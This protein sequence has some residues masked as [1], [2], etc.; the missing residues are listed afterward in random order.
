MSAFPMDDPRPESAPPPAKG[1]FHLALASIYFFGLAV[2][3]G[4]IF[5]MIDV[6]RGGED[7]VQRRWTRALV[8]LV[9]ADALV[10][11]GFFWV[12]NRSDEVFGAAFERGVELEF[13]IGLDAAGSEEGVRVTGVEE[14][15][16]AAQAGLRAGDRIVAVDGDRV[17]ARLELYPRL[18]EAAPRRLKIRRGEETLESTIVPLKR[19]PT[20]RKLFETFDPGEATGWSGLLAFL[21]ALGLALLV[22]LATPR[23]APRTGAWTGV[24]VVLLSAVLMEAAAGWTIRATVGGWSMGGVLLGMLCQ[25]VVLAGLAYALCAWKPAEPETPG[26]PWGAVFRRGIFYLLSGA[27]R[28]GVLLVAAGA[29]LGAGE[30]AA[31]DPFQEIARTDLGPWG[32]LLFV[33][34]VVLL[35]PL[36]EEFLFRGWLLPRLARQ[37]GPVPALVASSGVFALL[38]PHYSVQM[39]AI[40][41]LGLL[42]G[43]ARLRSG[44]LKA[45][46]ALHALINGIST[47]FLLS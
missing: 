26:E 12:L 18:R 29:L 28:V 45:P 10:A 30:A 22:R 46:I 39:G 5:A 9:A 47:I 6:I 40:F 24:L 4:W 35:A 2:V 19:T 36:G 13:H 15:S 43:W 3:V 31:T 14:G 23:G 42:L 44:G 17:D 7:P 25:H 38:H 21:P 32:R 41:G 11:L 20:E 34:P 27:P 1:H 37:I 8:A 16:P 33:V